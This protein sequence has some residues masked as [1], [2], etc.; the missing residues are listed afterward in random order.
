MTTPPGE[1]RHRRIFHDDLAFNVLCAGAIAG[2]RK[3]LILLH[4]GGSR[5]AHFTS[6]MQ[7]LAR[8]F[9]VLAYDQRGF[10]ATGATTATVIDHASWAQD[11]IALMDALE[12]PTA[13]LVGWSLGASVALNAAHLAPDRISQIVLLG[14]PD[15]GM[16]VDVG[17]LRVR[18]AERQA[19]DVSSRIA[20]DRAELSQR[21][22]ASAAARPGLLETLVADREASSLE[23]QERAIAAYTTRPDLRAVAATITCPVHLFVGD[24]DLVTPLQSAQRMAASLRNAELQIVPD[25]GHYYAVEQPEWL[26]LKIS[27]AYRS[28]SAR[29]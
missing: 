13:G 26:A 16:P 25:C 20:R 21:I 22:A 10:A 28:A 3:A 29:D 5:G 14:A 6:L 4:G 27:S 7:Y 9:F 19:Q 8:D 24:Q 12:M 23:L 11:V 1:L 18:H 17:K 15:P 2:T